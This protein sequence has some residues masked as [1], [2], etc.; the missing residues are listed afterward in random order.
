MM[1]INPTFSTLPLPKLVP[2]WRRHYTNTTLPELL[3][4][5]NCVINLYN[6]SRNMGMLP[7]FLDIYLIIKFNSWT[8][9]PCF[10]D[11]WNEAKQFFLDN[12]SLKWSNWKILFGYEIYILS[13]IFQAYFGKN[14]I[15]KIRKS[16]PETWA[17]Y[18]KSRV[19]I[20]GFRS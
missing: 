3:N 6:M 13:L 5:F 10:W 20:P 18:P 16:C 15:K 8:T 12:T 7:L 4:I 17:C 1:R 19:H 14:T 11:G 2:K 9:C